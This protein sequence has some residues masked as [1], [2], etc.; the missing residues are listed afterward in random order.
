MKRPVRPPRLGAGE[1]GPIL[2]IERVGPAERAR[3][4][5]R[6][7][8][9][10]DASQR[11]QPALSLAHVAPRLEAQPPRLYSAGELRNRFGAALRD[12]RARHLARHRGKVRE[13][14][15]AR[16]DGIAETASSRQQE[17]ER[18]F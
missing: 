6:R 5:Q 9:L 4:D 2:R 10:P 16:R 3:H 14:G 11:K 1:Q 7:E 8:A 12:A 17:L 13:S 18:D 15:D